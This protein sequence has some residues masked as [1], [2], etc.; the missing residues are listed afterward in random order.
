MASRGVLQAFG[1]AELKGDRIMLP[2]SILE[3]LQRDGLLEKDNI[4]HV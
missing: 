3:G 4:A 1:N 2:E